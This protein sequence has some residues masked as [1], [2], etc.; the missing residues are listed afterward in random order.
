MAC[1][2]AMGIPASRAPALNLLATHSNGERH[3]RSFN[4]RS[5]SLPLATSIIVLCG[6][7]HVARATDPPLQAPT[8]TPIRSTA[9]VAGLGR[10]ADAG[11]LERLSGGTD[12]SNRITLHGDVS[13]NNT[14]HTVTGNNS[15]G[16]GAFSGSVGLPMVIQNSGNS[17]LIQNATIVSVQFQP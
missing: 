2:H 15:I 4:M 5:V 12:I 10:S 6:A 1:S 13:N 7:T 16:T 14:D 3:Q 11:T 8:A 17:V 9:Y